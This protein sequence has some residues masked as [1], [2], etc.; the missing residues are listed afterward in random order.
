VRV[1][2]LW[3]LCLTAPVAVLVDASKSPADSFETFSS[4]TVNISY[5]VSLLCCPTICHSV[6]WTYPANSPAV[7]FCLPGFN[8]LEICAASGYNKDPTKTYKIFS[9]RLSWLCHAWFG[10]S[11]DFLQ[12][13]Y[14]SGAL[15]LSSQ[16]LQPLN[17]FQGSNFSPRTL[18]LWSL[19]LMPV[20]FLPFCVQKG[21]DLSLLLIPIC[22]T[23]RLPPSSF[24]GSRV[25]IY[26]W[27]LLLLRYLFVAYIAAGSLSPFAAARFNTL[28]RYLQLSLI[29]RDE[30][31]WLGGHYSFVSRV[32]VQQFGPAPPRA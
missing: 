32:H 18:I 4:I 11:T 6:I 29:R 22:A 26:L 21:I 15:A 25:V 13:L 16:A 24:V 27:M 14:R 28:R 1:Q 9:A 2:I 3:E 7:N 10:D 8:L 19:P 20:S 17:W 12:M 23:I 5:V 30:C 31:G